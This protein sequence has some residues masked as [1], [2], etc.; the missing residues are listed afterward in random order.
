MKAVILAAGYGTRMRPYT[1]SKPKHMLPLA[2]KPVLEHIVDNLKKA[3]ISEILII[4]GHLKEGIQDYFKNGAEFG[5]NI[6]YIEQVERKGLANAVGMSKNFVGGEPF[7]V[8][9]GDIIFTSDFGDILQKHGKSSAEATVLLTKVENPRAFGV[10]EMEGDRIKRLVEKPKVPPS[11]L[12]IAGVY[13]FSSGKIFDV[14]KGLKPSARGEYEITDALQ[15]LIDQNKK[16]CGIVLDKWWKDTGNP[17]DLLETNKAILE[18]QYA[19]KTGIGKGCSISQ[20]S[21]LIPPVLIGDNCTITGSI[22]GPYACV[23]KN[24]RIEKSAVK[25]SIIMDNTR[26]LNIDLDGAVV[27]SHCLLESD[28]HSKSHTHAYYI[29]DNSWVGISEKKQ[30]P[31]A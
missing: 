12:A 30:K 19:R 5:I 4:V 7:T 22:I 20:D 21:R 13:V 17:K 16:V 27:G 18:E 31:E 11:N 26:I 10:V 9:L 6:S 2:N 25:N 23:Q 29:G 15:G 3:G 14:I 8:V 24:T 28:L 1:Y